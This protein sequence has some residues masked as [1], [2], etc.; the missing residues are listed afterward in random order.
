VKLVL[1]EMY[2]RAI[3]AELCARGHDVASASE[4]NDLRAVPDP[5]LF[6]AMQIE[7][8][9]I[10]TN[11][12]RDFMPLAQQALQS[13]ATFYGVVFTSDRSLPR[14]KANTG[15]FVELLHAL[16]TTHAAQAALP[17]KIA[18]LSPS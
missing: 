2:A 4:R 16:M 9:V 8:R 13:G 12:V 10:V 18:W 1:D 7:G 14:S 11:N 17:G 15:T 3:A 6:D 5:V